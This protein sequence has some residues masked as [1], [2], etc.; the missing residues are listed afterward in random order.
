MNR[1]FGII[2]LWA[3]AMIC[4]MWL[5]STRVAVHS[6][7]ADLLPEGTTASQRLLLTQVRTGM[8]GRILLLA[9]EGGDPDTLAQASKAFGRRLLATGHFDVVENGAQALAK[10]DQ[11]EIGRAHV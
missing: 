6:E 8:A 4:G 7:L 3:L 9:I 5:V 11:D 2:G 1:R 10:S